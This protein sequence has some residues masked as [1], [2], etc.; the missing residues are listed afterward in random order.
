MLT[1]FT[2]IKMIKKL[3]DKILITSLINDKDF[4]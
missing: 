3:G 2:T 4:L 1:L